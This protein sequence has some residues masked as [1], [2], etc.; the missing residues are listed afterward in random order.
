MNRYILIALISV[1]L[2]LHAASANADS[3]LD[4]LLSESIE[5]TANKSAG[6]AA[7]APALSLS[8]TAEDLRRYGLRTLAEAYQ[9]LSMGIVSQDPLGEPEVGSRAVLFAADH[10]RHVLLLLDG[11]T[12]ND[13]ESGASLHGHGL[14][15]P[16][17]LI[18]HVEIVLGP[19]SVLYGAN[20]MFGVINVVT[21]KARDLAGAHVFADA[22]FSPPLNRAHDIIGPGGIS[23]YLQHLGQAYRVGATA[24]YEFRLA[25][26]PAELTLGVEYYSMVGPTLSWGPQARAQVSFGPRAPLG[27][28]GGQTTHNYYERT[29][30]A[31]VR[32]VLGEV[33]ATAHW[34]ASRRSEPY[35]P[36]REQPSEGG[37][38]DDP[39][40]Y[41]DRLQLGLELSWRRNLSSISSLLARTYAD[42]VDQSG[43]WHYHPHVGCGT[44]RY[45]SCAKTNSGYAKW[46][47][48]EIQTNFDW[49]GEG[50][51]T[52]MLGTDGRL[53][54]VGYQ[55]GLDL[56]DTGE[57]T[58][59][60]KVDR[61]EAAGAV[62]AQQVYRPAAWLTLNAGARWD[63]D[64]G[65]GS[66]ISPRGAVIAAPWPQAT[67]KGIYSEALRGPTTDEK[68]FRD[69]EW[70]LPPDKL[71][72]ESVRSIEV[73]LQQRFGAHNLVFGVFRSKWRDM[74]IAREMQDNFMDVDE[75]ARLIQAAK[76]SGVLSPSA[77]NVSQYQNVAS[78]DNFGFNG[79]YDA[80][81]W[82]GRLTYGFNLTSAYS[83]I[84]GPDGTRL[85]PVTPSIYGNAHLSYDLRE[86]LP[87]L[88]LAAH[89]SGK[90]LAD[91]GEDAGFERLPYAPP[92][93][94]LRL[95][96]TGR[97]MT[98]LSY[99]VMGDYTFATS[100][101]YTAG[102]IKTRLLG[103]AP[104]LIPSQRAS[105]MLG[106][107]YDLPSFGAV[108]AA[109]AGA[110]PQ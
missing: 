80:A 72:P 39:K 14:G 82:M 103:T 18:D 57:T 104:E 10:G 53:R 2:G 86:P 8:I 99:R 35:L 78:I 7:D 79:G 88:G 98:G 45:G 46:I 26:T 64:Q 36:R 1:S 37:D 54:R 28:W 24:G 42:V 58:T 76:R 61:T 97:I 100:N 20:A 17:E 40:A 41:Q 63:F 59:Y 12:L 25:D 66:R 50:S 87:V 3:E 71:H 31:Y 70:A 73:I 69:P 91:A 90:R 85:I 34:V 33:E 102:P 48:S 60:S 77:R 55:N 108:D 89:F 23:P 38:F 32:L 84:N 51:L 106:L 27:I 83:R 67:I 21:R 49:Y 95:T 30:S 5:S 93:L 44:A 15:L 107:Q 4:A 16:I 68:A 11:H 13:Q 81:S 74:I 56:L 105:V 52:T 94:G 29:P 101:P 62:Y 47:G 92:A 96:A 65:F 43:R 6:T 9:F 109:P 110:S 75:G 22:A 19:G